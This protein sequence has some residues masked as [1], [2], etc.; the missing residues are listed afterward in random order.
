MSQSSSPTR[1]LRPWASSSWAR[2]QAR[3]TENVLLPTP[4]LARRDR[5]G[6]ADFLRRAGIAR[7]IAT[8]GGHTGGGRRRLRGRNGDFDDDIFHP[9]QA[10]QRLLD[11]G[12][13]L[14]RRLRVIAGQRKC[15][16]DRAIEEARR[17]NQAERHDV[18]AEAGILHL[19]QLFLDLVG[20]H[21][22]ARL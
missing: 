1:P 6:V 10:A 20:R 16:L 7:E 22:V 18:P 12:L 14:Q 15:D 17:S 2:P 8:G 13:Q 11:V 9:R 19:L 4:P 5:D 21:G 3:L